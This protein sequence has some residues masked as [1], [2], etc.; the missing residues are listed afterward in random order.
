MLDMSEI[1]RN[2]VPPGTVET[3]N[4]H[5]LTPIPFLTWG[6]NKVVM[7]SFPIIQDGLIYA[8][9]IRNGLYIL[10]YTGPHGDEVSDIHFLEGNPNLGDALDLSEDGNLQ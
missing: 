8:V 9:D 7:W 5:L 3:L 2:Q 4:D 10:R 1:A 6:T